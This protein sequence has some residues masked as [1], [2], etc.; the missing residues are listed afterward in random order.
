MGAE[1]CRMRRRESSATSAHGRPYRSGDEGLRH[2]ASLPS[3]LSDAAG[4]FLCIL[5]P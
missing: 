4:R 3:F 2:E 5:L 1:I